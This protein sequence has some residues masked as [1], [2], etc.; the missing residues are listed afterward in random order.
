MARARDL[1]VISDLHLGVVGDGGKTPQILR[2]EQELCS[3]L[4]HHRADGRGWRLVINGDM[5]DLV[6]MTL[7]PAD[8]GFV[9]GFHPDDHHYGLGARAHA[10]ALKVE[11]VVRHHASVFRALG[12]FVAAG[13]SLAIVVGN[14]D[15]ELHWPE[16]QRVLLD[17]IAQAA[18]E[19]GGAPEH[20]ADAVT[21][22]GW[23]FL[24][25]GLAWI[26]HGHQYDPY[27]SF[28]EVLEPAT[29]TEEADPN[30]G[31]LLLRYLGPHMADDING[32]YDYTFFGYLRFWAAQGRTRLLGIGGAYLDV[33]RRMVQHWR[34][35]VPERIAARRARA[36]WRLREISKRLRLDEQRL[37]HLAALAMPPVSVD[38]LR[39]VRALMVDR[40]VLMLLAPLLIGLLLVLPWPWMP[41]AGLAA[42][43]VAWFA[44]HAVIAREPVDPSQAMRKIARRIRAI[45]RVPIVVM[46]HSHAAWAEGEGD[47][48]GAGA[49]FNTGTWV[50]HD[51]EQSFT[52]L[53]IER[54]ERGVRALLCQWRD[55]SSRAYERAG[56]YAFATIR[57]G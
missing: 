7:M 1:L 11:R 25:E 41:L 52:H 49:Y 16:V 39:I 38:L 47:G 55:G 46:G 44:R 10:A 56:A 12:R 28:E 15:V 42:V 22:H 27:C 19:A 18:M 14:H 13:N 30:I 40:L 31:A 3:F 32:A 21:V 53:R 23:F 17:G 51:P 33:V 45:A 43:P 2:L 35:R 6:G 5:I 37:L 48:E 26:E 9:T 36:R 57:R 8:A 54:T 24:E 50:A 20:F 29:D 34:A 4:E